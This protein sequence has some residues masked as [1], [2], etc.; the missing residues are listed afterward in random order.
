MQIILHKSFVGF[1]FCPSISIL[2]YVP[3]TYF[4]IVVITLV[5]HKKLCFVCIICALCVTV[6][7]LHNIQGKTPP[8]YKLNSQ[9]FM[10]KTLVCEA[11][12]RLEYLLL[13]LPH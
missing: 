8:M 6:G 9:I 13:P 2:G 12:E 3:H 10:P 1:V 11:N 4:L 7:I 5:I